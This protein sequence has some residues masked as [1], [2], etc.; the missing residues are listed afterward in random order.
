MIPM[1]MQGVNNHSK[2]KSIGSCLIDQKLK[3]IQ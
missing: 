1:T 3:R 2:Q